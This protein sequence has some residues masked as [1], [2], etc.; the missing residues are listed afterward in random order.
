MPEAPPRR[1]A[2]LLTT[3]LLIS[4]CSGGASSS[5]GTTQGTQASTRLHAL[6]AMDQRVARVAWRLSQAN[7]ELCPIVRQSA[8]WALHSA[9]QYSME[10]R[11]YAEAAFG[12][13]GDLPGVL[14]V[15]EG[16]PAAQAGLRQGD[17]ILSVNEAPLLTGFQGGRPQFE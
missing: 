14:S 16:S 11:P 10:L 3:S 17:L 4:A 9:N 7:A 15:P 5:I 1:L 12:L 2:V 6:T 13:N 8:G